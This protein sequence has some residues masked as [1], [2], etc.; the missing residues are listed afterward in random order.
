MLSQRGAGGFKKVTNL[1]I[2][3]FKVNA[4]GYKQYKTTYIFYAACYRKTL[5]VYKALIYDILTPFQ[6]VDQI[7]VREA[8][9]HFIMVMTDFFKT[10]FVRRFGKVVTSFNSL[11][12]NEL[13]SLFVVTDDNGAYTFT[14]GQPLPMLQDADPSLGQ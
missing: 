14:A 9:A 12:T 8:R 13:K 10:R 6:S 5:V 3:G 1:N 2:G 11:P 7:T 4:F